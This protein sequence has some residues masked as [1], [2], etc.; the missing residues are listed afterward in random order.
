MSRES[1]RDHAQRKQRPMVEDKVIAE[2][3]TSLLTPHFS[4]RVRSPSLKALC[5]QGLNPIET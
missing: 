5:N 1:N 4:P 3:L 2:Y